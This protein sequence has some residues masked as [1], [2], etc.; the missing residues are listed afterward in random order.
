MLKHNIKLAFRNF[1]KDKST[2]LIN[3]IGLSSGLA[4]A[5]LIGLWVNDEINFDKFHENDKQLFQVFENQISEGVISTISYNA[6]HLPSA[7]KEEFPEVKYS[8]EM[9]SV[10]DYI[11][12]VENRK[13]KG[14]GSFVGTD[15]FNA[16]S[17]P[18][19][20]GKKESILVNKNSVVISESFADTQPRV[21]A[22]RFPLGVR[23]CDRKN[24]TSTG[25]V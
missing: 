23:V 10:G 13:L 12:S 14:K 22:G 3:L 21:T 17:F 6:G 8:V 9:A 4:C 24:H 16:F 18:F 19:F 2:F 7:L 1:Q 20:L 5:F 15:F 25:F 11:L